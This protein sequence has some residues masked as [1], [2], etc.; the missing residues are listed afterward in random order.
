[1]IMYV[2]GSGNNNT[3]HENVP[4]KSQKPEADSSETWATGTQTQ[5][6]HN[7]SLQPRVLAS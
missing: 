7:R 2:I 4:K 6:S 3:V 1:M 5:H